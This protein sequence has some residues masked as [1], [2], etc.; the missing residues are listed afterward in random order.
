M[1]GWT[2]PLGEKVHPWGPSSL[3][4]NHVKIYNATR[5][6]ERLENKNTF[7][8]PT[9]KKRSSLL[10]CWHFFISLRIGSRCRLTEAVSSNCR[11]YCL[12]SLM[13][14]WHLSNHFSKL[15]FYAKNGRQEFWQKWVLSK[16]KSLTVYLAWQL[17]CTYKYT[18]SIVDILPI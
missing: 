6:L 9:L 17:M 14:F 11:L 13:K 3:G 18:Y 10:Q 15:F 12:N 2:F 4:A 1:K 8:L 7:I 5:S 16:L